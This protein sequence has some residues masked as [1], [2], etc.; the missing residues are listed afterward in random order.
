M[1]TILR[2]K[3]RWQGFTGAPGYSVFHMRDFTTEEPDNTDAQAA[4]D[5][6][7]TFAQTISGL[8]PYQSSLVVSNDVD[9]LEDT[10]GEMINVL[11]AVAD[12][13]HASGMPNTATFAGPVGAVITWRT[14]GV[15]NGRRIRG[16]TFLVPLVSAAFDNTGAVQSAA[17]ATIAGAA[18]ALAD[19]S[20]TPDLGVYARPS[21]PGATDGQWTAV[22]GY[23]IPSFGAV[24]RSRRD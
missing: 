3:M 20:G 5:R 9:V 7:D 4:V 19:A 12:A 10:T 1:A 13:P 16:R 8:M 18:T 14:G 11:S 2:V 23:S 6:I 22:T 15:R 21:G 24:L 17:A